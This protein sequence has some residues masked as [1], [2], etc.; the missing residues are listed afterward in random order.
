M[1]IVQLKNCIS[2]H[3]KTL[4]FYVNN[5]SFVYGLRSNALRSIALNLK[6]ELH[7]KFGKIKLLSYR[8]HEVVSVRLID[9]DEVRREK[10]LRKPVRCISRIGWLKL[11]LEEYEW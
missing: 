7:W 5:F 2:R 10:P 9:S 3:I 11:N 6:D 4:I 1:T 8:K